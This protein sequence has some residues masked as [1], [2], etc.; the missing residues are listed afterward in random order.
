MCWRPGHL[1]DDSGVGPEALEGAAEE[2]T[3][4][5]RFMQLSSKLKALMLPHM[6]RF[7]REWKAFV[8]LVTMFKWTVQ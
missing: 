6:Q 3:S 8:I 2:A 4:P 5:G 1:G 7:L